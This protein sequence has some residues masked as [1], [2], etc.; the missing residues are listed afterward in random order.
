[1]GGLIRVFELLLLVTLIGAAF[2]FI[3]SLVKKQNEE[4]DK[5]TNDKKEG[6]KK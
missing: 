2:A 3:V 5:N 1:M 4:K 6:K